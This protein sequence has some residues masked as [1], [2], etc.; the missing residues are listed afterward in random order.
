MQLDYN[1]AGSFFFLRVPRSDA[2]LVSTLM[3]EHGLDFSLSASTPSEAVLF[4]REPYAAVDFAEHGTDRAKTELAVTLAAIRSSWLNTSSAII[5]CPL[6]KELMP[7][8]C[9]SVAYAL[10]RRNTLVGDQPGLGKTPIAICYAN[11]IAAQRVLVICP[12]NIRIQWVNRIREWS[13]MRWPFI[14]YPILSGRHGVHPQAHWTVVSYDLARTATIGAALAQHHYDLVILD[15]AH[16]LKTIDSG[17][18]HAVFGDHTGWCREA[19]RGED[20]AIETY[21][22]LFPALAGRSERVMALTGTPLP[23][24]PRE[25][26]TLSRALCF[27]AID[28]MSEDAFKKRFNPSARITGERND[29]TLYVYNREEVG[30]AGELQSRLRANF[31]V[32][33]LK[34]DP[35]IKKQIKYAG[36]PSYDLVRVEETKTIKQILHAESLLGIDPDS[37]EAE[38]I[39]IDGQWPVIRHML[40]DAIAPQVAEYAA[41]CLDGGEEKI[42]I[43]A[44]HRS[45]LDYLEAKLA[46]F[47]VMRIDGSTS[48]TQRKHRIET[49]VGDKRVHIMIGNTI[50]L[51]TGTDGLQTVAFH[52]LLAE[53]D[54]VPG[55]N[56]QAVDRL[57]R[58]GQEGEVQ[59]DLFVAPGSLLER[60]LAKSLQKKQ[61]TNKVLDRRVS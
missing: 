28:W 6:D 26:Y 45:V 59:A 9:A 54:P 43:F 53:P 44:H 16:Y 3:T 55:N 52:A 47:G 15:E 58:M 13:T 20:D 11:E 22:K 51:G 33:H 41:M 4:T 7:F 57:D 30:R 50:S 35:E 37:F 21:R 2:K 18:T 60:I 48:P 5:K 49:F 39:K 29:G 10:V 42:V 25:A 32:R 24:R 8:Q 1:A 61:N 46:R 38:S 27:D 17:R 23:N 19:V 56:E 40:G 12:A 36:I 31:M 14:V 34:H